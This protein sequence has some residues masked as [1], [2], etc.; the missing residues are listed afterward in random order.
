MLKLFS[1]YFYFNIIDRQK[2]D[3][4]VCGNEWA[5]NTS[6]KMEARVGSHFHRHN[7]VARQ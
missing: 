2:C 6:H 1:I 3:V 7:S 5:W 4:R